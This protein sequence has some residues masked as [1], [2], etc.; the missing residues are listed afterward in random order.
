MSLR[1]EEAA[2]GLSASNEGVREP[3]RSL[4][5]IVRSLGPGLIIAGA[6][7]GSGE[8]IATTKTG[9]QAG[10]SLLWLIILG[11]LVKVFV[12][13]ELGRFAVSHGETTLLSLD[14]VPGPR[15]LGLNWV[16]WI[17]LVMMISTTGQLGGIVGGVGQAMAL[18]FPIRGDYERA[19]KLPGRD[20]FLRLIELERTGSEAPALSALHKRITEARSIGPESSAIIDEVSDRLR[21]NPDDDLLDAETRQELLEPKTYDDVL[22]AGLIAVVTS[23]LLYFGRYGLIQNI[24]IALVATFTLI[25]IGNVISLQ[26]TEQFALSGSEILDGFRFRAPPK[27]GD[28]NPWVTALAAFGIIGVGAT[29]LITYPY[30]CL[31]KGYAKFAGRNDG[32]SDWARRARGWIHVMKYDAFASMVVYTTATLAFFWMGVAVLHR[33]G[34]DPSGMRMVATLAETYVPVFGEYAKWLF[35]GGAFAVLYSTYLIA[36][37]GN[38]RMVTDGLRVARLIDRD[39]PVT[40]RRVLTAWSVGLPLLCFVI[41]T[42]GVDPVT[43]I[44]IAGLTQAVML[45][46]LGISSIYFRYRLTDKQLRPGPAWDACLLL[47][48]LALLVA[49]A[50]GVYAK[51]SAEGVFTWLA[52][53]GS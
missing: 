37:A 51:L 41:F 45:P 33:Q 19:V 11:C 2:F 42:S 36:T 29:E 12:Q 44:L 25:T 5:G 26:S 23:V 30:W 21:R 9:A 7:V 31:E 18:A 24:S 14:R 20:E 34:L 35:L 16:L 15:L 40:Y 53:P 8:L 4:G 38:A 3:P 43:L 48:S 46:V 13:I 32:S 28:Q 22:W 52:G 10:I 17:W 47:S 50:Y 6:I 1:P 27:I 39:N 49:G